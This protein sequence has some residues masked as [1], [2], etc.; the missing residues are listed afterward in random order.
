M[1]SLKTVAYHLGNVYTKLGA[2]S[3]SQLA[4]RF[5]ASPR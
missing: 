5:A 2:S 3:R 4:A 1:V